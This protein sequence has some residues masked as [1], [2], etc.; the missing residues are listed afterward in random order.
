MNLFTAF[1]RTLFTRTRAAAIGLDMSEQG[2][3][4]VELCEGGPASSPQLLLRRCVV[5]PLAPGCIVEGRVLQFQE[6]EAALGRL[7][8][9]RSA[10]DG[11]GSPMPALALGVPAQLA[12]RGSAR[13]PAALRE[14]ALAERVQTAMA[15][16]LHCAPDDLCVDFQVR[17]ALAGAP[18][19]A[20][21]DVDMAAVPREAV[22][23]RLAL[24]ESVGLR[25]ALL[26]LTPEVG[27]VA[28]QA[29][30]PTDF[31]RGD[32]SLKGQAPDGAEYLVARGL[33]LQALTSLT[34]LRSP[35]GPTGPNSNASFNFLPHRQA[36]LARRQ[37]SFLLNLAATL[38]LTL[39]ATVIFRLLLSQEL[40]A[41]QATGQQL[42]SQ[43]T[44]LDAQAKR[45]TALESELQALARQE[46]RIAAFDAARQQTP[47]LFEELWGL[48]PE[49]LFLTSLQREASSYLLAGQARSPAE[50]FAFIERL[51]IGS[52]HFIKP[53]LLDLAVMPDAAAPA[54]PSPQSP[55]SLPS[56][57][58]PPVPPALTSGER[59]AERYAFTLRAEQP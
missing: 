49:G 44:A 12:T 45:L 39:G 56:V 51:K 24:L 8:G 1:G 21:V 42:R 54:P 43:I 41:R 35:K 58:V 34:S 4:W 17:L 5:E 29:A 59:I 26:T 15:E 33:A 19:G 6:V 37:K 32:A 23:D 40:S 9:T 57:P 53:S 13:F 2:L 18:A 3:R 14:S 16:R 7:M 55:Q 30:L 25:P 31:A 47:L 20:E 52:Q 50:V 27:L 36:A 22:E 10:S 28:A 38:L 46:S 48:V 11:P